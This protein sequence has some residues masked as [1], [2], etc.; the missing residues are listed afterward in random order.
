MAELFN[1]WSDGAPMLLPGASGDFSDWSDGG[2]V[3]L[4]APPEFSLGLPNTILPP[5]F[6]DTPPDWLK[7]VSVV[8]RWDTAIQVNREGGEQRANIM[9]RPKL[10]LTYSRSA[11][12]PQQF[13]INRAKAMKEV[14][15][16]VVVPVWTEYGA[17]D[18]FAANSVTLTATIT[19]LKFKIG[20][21]IYVTQVANA[22][23]RK[24]ASVA[25]A[26]ISLSSSAADFSPVGFNWSLFTSGA[27]VY[28]C[29][30]GMR[31]DNSYRY[32]LNRVDRSDAFVTVEEL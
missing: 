14:G 32:S 5:V 6:L 10:G 18:S 23:F 22:C 28:P 20:S 24:I 12:R 17:A 16:A 3:V 26:T 9:A 7:P 27:R 8:T 29:V 25:A 4:G 31:A 19:S 1:Y 21:W 13:A 15:A 2:P 11:L 30:L